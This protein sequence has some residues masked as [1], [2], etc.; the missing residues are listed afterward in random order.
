MEYRPSSISSHIPK[1]FPRIYRED[2][3]DFIAFVKTYYEF[4]D[5]SNTR[6][7]SKLGDIDNTLEEFLKYYKR[8]YLHGLPFPESSTQDIPFIVKNISDLYR[9]KGTKEALELMFMMFYKEEI[10][11]YYP[12][13]SIL[14]LSD[15]TWAFA[16]YLEFKPVTST[17]D[18]PIKKGDVIEGDTSKAT[19]FVDQ[20]VFYNIDGVQLPVGYI[21]N[22]YGRFTSDDSLKVTRN[23]IE[24]FPG[25]VIYGS[26]AKPEVLDK[27]VTANNKLGDKVKLVSSR[28][29]IQ[30]EGVVR[31]ISDIPTGSIEFEL[32]EGGWGFDTTV[33]TEVNQLYRDV[34]DN[35]LLISSQVLIVTANPNPSFHEAASLLLKP[36]ATI[37][38]DGLGINGGLKDVDANE[39]ITGAHDENIFRGQATV[40]KYEHP[41]LYVSS[42]DPNATD[43]ST[44]QGID[45]NSPFLDGAFHVRDADDNLIIVE[46]FPTN[47]VGAVKVTGLNGQTGTFYISGFSEFNDTAGYEPE[48]F[49]NTESVTFFTDII[50]D[51]ANTTLSPPVI[52]D[53]DDIQPG[54]QYE[55]LTVS[56]DFDYSQPLF[57]IIT[58]QEGQIFTISQFTYDQYYATTDFNGFAGGALVD[59]TAA[60]YGMS[61]NIHTDARTRLADALGAQD[62]TLGSINTIKVTSSGSGFTNNV[63]SLVRNPSMTAFSYGPLAVRFD[64]SNFGIQIG[65]VLEQTIQVPNLARNEQGQF[66]NLTETLYYTARAKLIR[67]NDVTDEFIFQQISFYPFDLGG[68]DI[69]FS[70]NTIRIVSLSRVQ[71]DDLVLGENSFVDG[72]ASYLAG[73]ITGI[74]V[75]KSGFR[76]QT[77]E[78]VKLVNIDEDNVDKYN[79]WVGTAKLTVNDVGITEGKWVTTTSHLSDSNR[80][81]HDNDYYQE[82]SYDVSTILDPSVYEKTLKD[83]VHVAGTK[84]FGTPLV[85]AINDVTPQVDSNVVKL[86]RREEYM[87]TNRNDSTIEY[88]E[89]GSPGSYTSVTTEF[90]VSG[91]FEIGLPYIIVSIVDAADQAQWNITAGTGAD[92]YNAGSRFVAATN[93]SN[94]PTGYVAIPA[95][96]IAELEESP[97]VIVP[98]S[99]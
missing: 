63:R 14:T 36:G 31:Q 53:E 67:K 17:T 21:S 84:F 87:I 88:I 90:V 85:S 58:P 61:G 35:D 71:E 7:F 26:V 80:Y 96:F 81:I 70:G 18:F 32:Q 86:S 78:E 12:A 89:L 49:T 92:T 69:V 82:Y 24:S 41:L 83:T 72:K 77:G 25:R 44:P 98:F 47:T 66:T 19:A 33:P 97:Q 79:Q 54:V 65:D 74:D 56:N 99:T 68:E 42:Y 5:Q 1:Q 34:S 50:G 2:A 73:Q 37:S 95:R 51:F 59:R 29:G 13:S 40:I 16:T 27:D 62:A 60:N 48:T 52:T 43:F 94:L 91:S 11:T 57:N 38:T 20:V 76:Y 10:E 30:G 46:D 39:Q 4:L 45:V 75:V 28:Y 23:G 9:S 22:V 6:N 8:K 93:G 55:I 3:P 64:K 15:S